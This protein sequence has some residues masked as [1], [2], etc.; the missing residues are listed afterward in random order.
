MLRD[1]DI[2]PL[3]KVSLVT[4]ERLLTKLEKMSFDDWTDYKQDQ[5]QRL[6]K[7]MDI[8]IDNAKCSMTENK[9]ECNFEDMIMNIAQRYEVIIVRSIDTSK[10]IKTQVKNTR[11][12]RRA[13]VG[14]YLRLP[15]SS[16]FKYD[17]KG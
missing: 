15:I 8:F 13:V 11:T 16:G 10:S 2:D 7:A 1:L 17:S 12:N 3:T 5:L 14:G 9:E 6:I 4:V